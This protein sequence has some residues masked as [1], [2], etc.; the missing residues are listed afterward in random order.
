VRTTGHRIDLLKLAW[1]SGPVGDTTGI[2]ENFFDRLATREGLVARRS[3]KGGLLPTMDALA[4]GSFDPKLIHPAVRRFYE[5]TAEYEL[6]AWAE[7]CGIFRPFG[8][9]LALL[10]SRRLQQLNVPL[11]GLD[12]RL[13]ATS[14]VIQLVDPVSGQLHYTG[15]LRT[16][17]A[18]QNVL[19]AGSYSVSQVPGLERPCVKVVFPLPN[20]NAQ[21][22]LKPEIDLDGS[23]TITSSGQRFGDPGFYFTV[24]HD[25][26][27][28][29]C[30]VR[31]MQESIRVYPD[32]RDV[33]ADHQMWLW[34]ATFLRLHYRLRPSPD[35]GAL[36]A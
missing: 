4:G 32:G 26:Q 3:D 13:G 30:Y 29:A 24:H 15:W 16:L 2:G 18:T 28:W 34:R 19:Y 36:V 35:T 14:A 5:R 17:R 6:E 22:F 9:L 21:I 7:W 12:L 20:G 31:A 27:V 1:L 10:F 8:R 11:S 23:L 25:G 33:R